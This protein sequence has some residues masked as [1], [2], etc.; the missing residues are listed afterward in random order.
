MQQAKDFYDES[1]CV[2]ELIATL[3]DKDLK[4][5]TLFKRWT[6]EDVIGHLYLFNV[7]AVETL[8]S[9][10]DFYKFYAPIDKELEKGKSLIEAQVPW[11]DGLTGNQL[12][13]EW[14]KS[15]QEVYDAYKIADPK[16]RVKWP[17]VEMSAKS[18]ITARHM[19]TW[20]HG[21]EVFDVLGK[22]RTGNDNIKN[23]AHMGIIAYG[24]TFMNRK[25]PVPEPVPYVTLVAPSGAVWEWNDSS[26]TSRIS[27]SAIEFS[28]VVTQV[29][30]IA[31]TSLITEGQ[32]A[33][34][35]MKFAQ[36]FAGPPM[37]PPAKGTR[38]MA[39][40]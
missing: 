11:L 34:D 1:E 16:A 14:W 30:N 28:Q 3:S 18:K 5:E 6:I 39:K 13:E 25:L 37:D 32:P 27:G 29:R 36:C 12:V 38:Y 17:G 24:W 20:A 23:I 35:W 2:K 7:G 15:V 31:D 40:V 9:E 10:A 26:S 4:T 21:H 8:K 19:E 33:E 22:E